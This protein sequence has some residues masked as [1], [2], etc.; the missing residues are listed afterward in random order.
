[1]ALALVED[2]RIRSEVFIDERGAA[3]AALG[4]ALVSG[5]PAVALCTS[6]TAAAHFLAAVVEAHLSA[7]PMIVCT[8]D[9]PPELRDVGAAQTIDQTFLY[10]TDV[11]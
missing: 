6:G 2:G 11:P 7:V 9:R 8:A 10:R 4:S 5:T 3:F 1:M